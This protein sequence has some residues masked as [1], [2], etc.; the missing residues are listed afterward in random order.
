MKSKPKVESKPVGRPAMHVI[1]RCIA[2]TD[3]DYTF[4]KSLGYGGLSV[5]IR[6]ALAIV[7]GKSCSDDA[8]Y[9]DRDTCCPLH[10]NIKPTQR[11][12]TEAN[13]SK[14]QEQERTKT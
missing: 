6:Q 2:L 4:A 3:A 7:R 1:R 10:I 9:C 14:Q 11:A 8:Q 12:I 5:G 13:K